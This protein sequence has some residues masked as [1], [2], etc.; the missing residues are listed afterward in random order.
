MRGRAKTSDKP[1]IIGLLS[2]AAMCRTIWHGVRADDPYADWWRLKVD[3]AIREARAVLDREGCSLDPLFAG[4]SAVAVQPARSEKPVRIALNFTNPDAFRVAQVIGHFDGVVC[5]LLALAHTGTLDR[6]DARHRLERSGRAVR[7]VLQS[8]V[9]YRYLGLDRSAVRQGTA[10]VIQARESMGDC[11]QSLLDKA[12]RHP[13]HRPPQ[14]GAATTGSDSDSDTVDPDWAQPM[15][16]LAG[17]VGI[18]RVPDADAH[19]EEDH[20]P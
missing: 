2:F 17:P 16:E 10:L 11:P 15:D 20:E 18:P 3:G 13:V 7:R 1:A 6:D 14:P 19:S 5:S 8:A 12:Y 9:G 4:D